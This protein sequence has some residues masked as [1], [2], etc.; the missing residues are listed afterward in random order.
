[1][2]SVLPLPLKNLNYLQAKVGEAETRKFPPIPQIG[3]FRSIFLW[4]TVVSLLESC[5]PFW[6]KN[7]NN[8]VE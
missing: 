7:I 6:S 4:K 8:Y 5:L 3:G 2:R 1:M